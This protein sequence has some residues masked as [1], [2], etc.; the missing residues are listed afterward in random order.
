MFPSMALGYCYE[1]SEPNIPS[2]Y[3]A[4]F[5]EIKS[6]ESNVEDFISEVEDYKNIEINRK[7][8]KTNRV[9]D[10][11][12]YISNTNKFKNTKTFITFIFFIYCF[13][14]RFFTF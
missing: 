1:P 6:A 8:I 7:I 3:F 9:G 13:S 12:W 4:D 2:G 11:I 14:I 5:D 10:H